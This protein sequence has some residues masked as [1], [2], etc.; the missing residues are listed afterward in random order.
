MKYK[1]L[2]TAKTL[3]VRTLANAPEDLGRDDKV[4]T[5]IPQLFDGTSPAVIIGNLTYNQISP[6]KTETPHISI[7]DCPSAYDSEVSNLWG[8]KTDIFF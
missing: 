1:I 5:A 6:P 4:A 2:F 3:R 7:S 8:K